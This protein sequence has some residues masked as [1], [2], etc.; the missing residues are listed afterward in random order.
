MLSFSKFVTEGGGYGHLSHPWDADH[1]T[2]A[3]LKE[4]IINALSGKLEYTRE[5]TDAV[6]LMVS[7]KNGRLIAARSKTHLKN[8]GD[9]AMDTNAVI[10]KFKGRPL[11]IA[12]GEAMRDLTAAFSKLTEKQRQKVFNEGKSWMSLEV[13]MPHNAENVLRYG[14]TEL[15]LQ[16]VLSYNDAGEAIAYDPIAARMVEGMLRQVNADKQATF[17]IRTLNKVSLPPVDSYDKKKKQYLS[18]YKSIMSK[19]GV[20]SNDTILDAKK[21]YF[22]NKLIQLDVNNELDHSNTTSILNRWA[23]EDKS[24]RLLSLSNLISPELFK[25]IKEFDSKVGE[26]YKE[27]VKPLELLFLR[28]GADVLLMMTDF[29]AVSKDETIQKLRFEIEDV[30]NAVR[31]S[32]NPDLIKKL[33]YELERLDAVGGMSKIVPTE[34]I[35]F[36]HKGEIL[37]FTGLFAPLNQIIGLR[38]R[39]P[40]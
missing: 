34:G 35:T 21:K 15:R 16:D 29:M 23:L 11:E 9:D 20:S 14:I 10:E 1:F 4:I 19:Y 31:K 24:F 7:W 40:Q 6:N 36:F 8:A 25:K 22:Q 33:E 37:K 2:F 3:D 18:E 27:F 38:F 13:M 30:S 17:H 12:Y 5:K 28:I 26:Y 32:N 39:L